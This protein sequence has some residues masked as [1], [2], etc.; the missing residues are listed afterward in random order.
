MQLGPPAGRATRCERRSN[1]SI[2]PN[3][4][5]PSTSATTDEV[6]WLS[7]R[8]CCDKT[9]DRDR[10]ANN[11]R[12]TTT[13]TTTQIE[14]AGRRS[15]RVAATDRHQ[16]PWTLSHWERPGRLACLPASWNLQTSR[17]RLRQAFLPTKGV[18]TVPRRR[19][20]QPVVAPSSSLGTLPPS[21]RLT[22]RCEVGGGGL[23]H[24]RLDSSCAVRT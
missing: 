11:K 12:Q 21:Q 3:L 6:G 18:I 20:I 13:T 8:L 19:L 16:E 17:R 4:T 5:D 10:Q 7:R 23:P 14:E 22:P 2:L 15:V 24:S 1:C 9:R